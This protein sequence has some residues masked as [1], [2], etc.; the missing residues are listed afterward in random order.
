MLADGQYVGA[1]DGLREWQEY[2]DLL[3]PMLT[4]P[5]TRAP[6]VG[7]AVNAAGGAPACH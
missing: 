3:R 7:I 4:A 2:L 5:P 1:I 6:T